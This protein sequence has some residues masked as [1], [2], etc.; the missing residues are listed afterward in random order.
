M[1]PKSEVLPPQAVAPSMQPISPAN[2]VN[3]AEKPSRMGS[4]IESLAPEFPV[5]IGVPN[6]DFHGKTLDSSPPVTTPLAQVSP[7]SI[8]FPLQNPA[9]IPGFAVPPASFTLPA[10]NGSRDGVPIVAP[11]KISHLKPSNYSQAKVPAVSPTSLTS[12]SISGNRYS[13]P[14]PAPLKELLSP[15]SPVNYSQPKGLAIPAADNHGA[16]ASPPKDLSIHESD[17][18]QKMSPVSPISFISPANH[19]KDSNKPV[20]PPSK[21]LPRHS[22]PV[23]HLHPTG[24]ATSP[25]TSI[26][27]SVHENYSMPVVAPPDNLSNHSA[28]DNYSH[29]Q[30]P[31]LSPET[32]LSPAIHW[33]HDIPVAAPPADLSKYSTPVNYSRPEEHVMPPVTAVSPAIH[34]SHD[35]AVAPPPE[36]L[37]NHTTHANYSHP[38]AP[39]TSPVLATPPP[40]HINYRIPVAAPPKETSSH[41]S[42]VNGPHSRGAIPPVIATPPPIHKDYGIPVAAPPKETS[43]HF[44]H[45]NS[46]NSPRSRG[47]IPPVI[48]T[49]PP[50]HKHYGIPVAAPPKEISSHLSPVNDPHLR[51]SFPVVSP[52]PHEAEVPSD[53]THAPLSSRLQ[54]PEEVP[55]GPSPMPAVSSHQY[56]PWKRRGNPSSSPSPLLPPDHHVP[57]SK[58]KPM[59]HAPPPHAQDS[60]GA[61]APIASKVAPLTHHRGHI[62]IPVASPSESVRR[63]PMAPRV[64]PIHALPPPPPS[65]DCTPLICYEPYT[66]S[67]PGSPCTC[68]FP[69]KVGLRLSISLFTFFPLVFEFAQEIAFGT[70]INQSQVRIMGANADSQ[71]PEKTIVLVDLLPFE[72]TFENSTLFSVYDKFWHKQVFINPSYF[73]DYEVLYVTYPGLPPSPPPTALENTNDSSGDNNSFRTL[74]PF[75]VDVRKQKGKKNRSVVAILVLSAVI[76]FILCVGAVWLLL[77]KCRARS[78]HPQIPQALTH[79][80]PKS[81]G[82][83]PTMA[84]SKQTSTSAS[85][86]SSIRTYAG[87]TKTFSIAE[88]EKATNNFDDLRII[89]E[90]GFGRVY[91]G[92]LEDGSSVAIKVLKREDQQGNREFLAEVEMLSRLHHRNLIK[93]IGICTEEHNC[94]VYELVRNGSVE[95]HLHD[96]LRPPGQ[97]NLVTWARPLLT[98]K[99]GLESIVDPS[100]GPD[101]QFDSLAK[102]AAIASM[103]VQPEV[104]QR[105]F[106]GEVVQALKL[107]CNEGE[108]GRISGSCSLEEMSTMRDKEP[109]IGA[110]WDLESERVLSEPDILSISA[111]FTRDVS[112]S[113]RR[114]SSSGPLRPASSSQQF[115][116]RTRGLTPGSASEHGTFDKGLE[117]G[118]QWV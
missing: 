106:M 113:F 61:P 12:P 108:D 22:P 100:L 9:K 98:S 64:Q 109:R 51:G 91:E 45:A 41:F 105:P 90:G 77:L 78:R 39:V 69:I 50:I 14:V 66:N 44:S 2:H 3:V 48:A 27:P 72:Y 33:S 99:D 4:P 1:M 42:P 87:S 95:S 63:K 62:Q 74:H 75:A 31:A 88:M 37:L 58:I 118:E 13:I 84:G 103:C 83:G 70:S 25:V 46:A 68:V 80:L 36:D 32:A 19:D 29:P 54:P 15:L 55:D 115:L 38:K 23:N 7:P 102:V 20:A 56:T 93:L 26:S 111:R 28:P 112:G 76:S 81:L 107:V 16:P 30:E 21:D 71:N 34:E 101:I 10:T 114:Y 11:P 65:L 104:D 85:F 35:M 92:T 94:L 117:A 97:E 89:G 79:P 53:S 67:R 59:V 73:V 17:S 86:S 40:I 49:P 110:G 6:S 82:A 60:Q 18:H 57:P 52:A 8:K 5:P 116:H 43:S 96:M 47:A 24:P